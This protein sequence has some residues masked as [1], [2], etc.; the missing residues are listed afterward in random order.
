MVFS[1][2]RQVPSLSH[3]VQAAGWSW[4]GIVPW[5]KGNSRPMLGRFRQQCEYI[6]FATKGPHNLGTRQCLPGVYKFPVIVSQ[7]IH[8]TSKPVELI[9]SL[10]TITGPE[11]MV[12]D[13]F[14]GGG[15]T[16]VACLETGRKFVGV[17]LSKE[18]YALSCERIRQTL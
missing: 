13:P 6:L 7:K 8:L 1:D 12:I 14:M 18:Y 11:S 4:R 9:K 16:G 5:D 17:E 2:W 3:A 15:T 10:L